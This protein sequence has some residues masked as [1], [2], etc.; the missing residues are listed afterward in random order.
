MML[1]AY[2][3]HVAHDLIESGGAHSVSEAIA[4]AVVIIKHWAAGKLVGNEKG[5]IHPDVRAAAAKALA[6]WEA[7]RR[8][9]HAAHA[10][11]HSHSNGGT[12]MSSV[13]LALGGSYGL[14]RVGEGA[15]KIGIGINSGKALKNE[16]GLYT[17]LKQKLASHLRNV[18]RLS[19]SYEHMVLPRLHEIHAQD[20]MSGT[21]MPHE[22]PTG[23]EPR[24][25]TLGDGAMLANAYG[26]RTSY[27]A[28]G[29]PIDLA[30][31]APVVSSQ[32]GPRMTGKSSG[33]KKGNYI[34]FEKLVQRIMSKGKS[35]AQAEAIAAFVGR[36]KYGAKNFQKAAASGKKLGG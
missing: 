34:G 30:G 19:G 21:I 31:V 33:G 11:S 1:P 8:I 35:R 13:D 7:K 32:D 2:I 20:H 36:R 5:H 9:A 25:Q 29:K 6:E 12:S 28:W 15:Q 14:P 3:Q 4:K 26:V 24:M 18:H 17:G 10:H 23:L 22:H 27:D 16:E